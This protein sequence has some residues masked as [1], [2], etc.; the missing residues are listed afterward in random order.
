LRSRSRRAAVTAKPEFVAET[1]ERE[2]LSGK[3]QF[4]ARLE[5]ENKLVHRFAVSRSTVRKGL[6]ALAGKG[7]IATRVGIGSFVTFNGQTIDNALGWTR[8]LGNQDG[9]VETRLL[10]LARI[11]D[12][13]LATELKL[14]E[15]D[16]LAIDRTRILARS[17]RVVSIE[18]SR[19]PFRRE[20]A[21]VLENGLTRGSL[22][23][24]FREAGLL[25]HSGEEWA[26]IERLGPTDAKLAGTATGTPFLRTRRLVRDG[27][28]HVIEYVV[29]LL[30]PKHFALHLEF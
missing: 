1:L 15:A 8:A 19:V 26:E 3:L 22:S 12:H 27:E 25:P 30:D 11:R 16:F 2:I 17:G 18:R 29:S 23:A 7:L 9:Q 28:G 21:H 24:T 4:G 10:Q 14:V 6:E 5:S 13:A 20:F